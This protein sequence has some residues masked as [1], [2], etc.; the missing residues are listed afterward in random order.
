MV[1]GALSLAHDQKDQYDTFSCSFPNHVAGGKCSWFVY[2]C[3]IYHKMVEFT[4]VQNNMVHFVAKKKKKGK[5]RNL[6]TSWTQN[7]WS[8]LQIW[9][10]QNT[11]TFHTHFLVFLRII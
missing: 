11:W 6:N 7:T 3:F 4:N 10:P 9:Y 2:N 5:K 8:D 1:G